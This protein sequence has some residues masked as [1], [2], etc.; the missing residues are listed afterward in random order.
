ML[1]VRALPRGGPV[2]QRLEQGTHNLAF[3]PRRRLI[4]YTE[5]E[6]ARHLTTIKDRHNVNIASTAVTEG[7]LRDWRFARIAQNYAIRASDFFSCTVKHKWLFPRAC[8]AL[9]SFLSAGRQ[10][11]KHP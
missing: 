3:R 10:V 2:A 7:F 5:G 6:Q 1:D 4:A 9:E 8:I 11:G